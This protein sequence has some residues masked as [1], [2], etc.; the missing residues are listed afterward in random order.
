MKIIFNINYRT[1]WGEALYICGD[2]PVM[3]AGNDE[4]ALQLNFLGGESWQIEL[5]LDDLEIGRAHV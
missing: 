4:N 1:R 5:D 3:G 2:L